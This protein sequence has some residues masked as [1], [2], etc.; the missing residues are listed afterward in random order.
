MPIAC[1]GTH[2]NAWR[3]AETERKATGLDHDLTPTW[4]DPMHCG[5]C[6]ERTRSQLAELPEL[7][8]AIWLEATHGTRPKTTGTVNR[9]TTPAWPGEASRLLTDHIVGG[10]LDLEDDVRDLQRLNPRV[11]NQREG[12]LAARAVSFLSIHL[13]WTLEHHP[14]ADEPHQHLSGNPASQIHGWHAAALRF[15]HRDVRMDHPQVPCPRCDLLA[16]YRADG[17][18]YIECRNIECGLL[19][20]PDEYEA[21][22][23]ARAAEHARKAAA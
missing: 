9:T 20:T 4:G 23:R 14:M 18:D 19:L 8:A 7:L 5:Y 10:L 22:T 2:N 1:P 21:Y 13:D 11:P 12:T 16:L 17:D 3:R 15:T 6:S